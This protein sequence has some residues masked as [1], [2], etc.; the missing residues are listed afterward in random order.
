MCDRRVHPHPETKTR[1]KSRPTATTGEGDVS[2][3][4]N[5]STDPT[6]SRL[7]ELQRELAELKQEKKEAQRELAELQ[8]EKKEVLATLE[9]L[10]LV[11]MIEWT[12]IAEHPDTPSD[13]EREARSMYALLHAILTPV[14]AGSLGHTLSI[15]RTSRCL[16]EATSSRAKQI[17]ERIRKGDSEEGGGSGEEGS[18]SSQA[19]QD[20]RGDDSV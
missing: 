1:A 15:L 18:G 6:Q 14:C 10:L 7:Q 9:R 8:Q 20:R 17:M 11:R 13:L 3:A 19:G 12:K 5:N 2:H 4:S 16:M